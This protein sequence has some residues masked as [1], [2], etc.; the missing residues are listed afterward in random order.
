MR[1]SHSTSRSSIFCSL[2]EALIVALSFALATSLVVAVQGHAQ[3]PAP[4]TNSPGWVVIPVS[5]YESLRARAFPAEHE[6]EAPPVEATLTRVDYDL[7]VNSSGDLAYG[8]AS[9]T[10][11]VIKDGWVRVAIPAGL[12]VREARLDGKEVSLVSGV[13]GKSGQLSALL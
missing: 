11:D 6:P 9:L 1:T 3:E 10:V 4:S 8:R 2:R 13:A 12:L 5:E 7:Q